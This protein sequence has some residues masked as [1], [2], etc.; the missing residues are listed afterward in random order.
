[1]TT[2]TDIRPDSTAAPSIDQPPRFSQV[3]IEFEYPVGDTPASDGPDTYANRSNGL[4]GYDWQ[5]GVEG[6]P[7][8]SRDNGE[9]GRDH[10]GAEIRSPVFDLHTDQTEAWYE[11]SIAHAED[12][13]FNFAAN[14]R[15][16]TTFGLHTHMSDLN[17][18]QV[19]FIQDLCANEPWMRAFVCA[20]LSPN[21][22]DPW[23]HAGVRYSSLWPN[24]NSGG[25]R[26]MRNQFSDSDTHYEWRLPEPVVP[27]HLEMILHFLRL[28][29]FEE[30]DAAA[31]YAR[32]RVESRDLRLTAVQQYHLFSEQRD[33]WPRS[34]C[35]EEGNATTPEAAE[36]F[37]DVMQ[38]VYDD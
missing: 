4:R 12:A 24:G 18:Q 10:V 35:F 3:G 33:N 6:V 2:T 32:E 19:T 23:R 8:V 1:M 14:G 20:S 5:L 21:S 15:G 36:Y 30:Y 17:E 26:V 29:S 25:G 11:A 22:M 7:D 13:G 38:G 9:A 27:E 28:V 31:D 34:E 16:D 37:A